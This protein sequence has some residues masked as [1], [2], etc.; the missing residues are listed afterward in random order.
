MTARLSLTPQL[1]ETLP[2]PDS[3][4]PACHSFTVVTLSSS[5]MLERAKAGFFKN[6]RP[7]LYNPASHT[8]RAMPLP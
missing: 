2:D 3:H 6:M 4:D 5:E 1:R 8:L 7:C